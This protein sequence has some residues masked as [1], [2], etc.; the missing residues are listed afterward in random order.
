MKKEVTEK[1]ITLVTAAFGFVAALAWNSA[2]QE[3][4]KKF[5]E[6]YNTLPMMFIYAILITLFAALVTLWLAKIIYKK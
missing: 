4:F 6:N 2:I 5:S 3:T 1:F